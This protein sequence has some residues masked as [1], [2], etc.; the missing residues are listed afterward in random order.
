MQHHGKNVCIARA[1]KMPRNIS[2]NY[3]KEKIMNQSKTV[4]RRLGWLFLKSGNILNACEKCQ[5]LGKG[6]KIKRLKRIRVI[7]VR[8]EPLSAITADDCVTEGFPEMAPID[9]IEFFCKTMN[10]EPETFVTRIEFEYL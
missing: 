5:G 1:I 6:G 7:D 8:R 4:T 3:S 10:C 2:F 9:F